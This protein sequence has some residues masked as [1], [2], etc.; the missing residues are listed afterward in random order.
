MKQIERKARYLESCLADRA[1]GMPCR[2]A[3]RGSS[4]ENLMAEVTSLQETK[5][6]L[7]LV[8]EDIKQEI[9][10]VLVDIDFSGRD[11]TLQ[12]FVEHMNQYIDQFLD[13]H[14]LQ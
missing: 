13:S 12:N 5:A 8:I 7:D 4:I 1:K 6:N 10:K 9:A 3:A 11:A 14:F 2:L